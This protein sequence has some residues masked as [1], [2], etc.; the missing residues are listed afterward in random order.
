MIEP[1]PNLRSIWESA[2]S[3]AFDLSIDEPSTR[4]NAVVMLPLLIGP[5]SEDSNGSTEQRTRFV[6]GSQYVLRPVPR[7]AVLSSNS[8]AFVPI[9]FGMAE[10]IRQF[11]VVS[12]TA[13]FS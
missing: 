1:L 10:R 8:E 9:S 4:R 2:A 7:W 13:P 5:D 11:R 3:R 6:L 12:A